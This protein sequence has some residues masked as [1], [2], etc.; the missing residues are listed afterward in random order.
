MPRYRVLA[1]S[2]INDRIVHPGDI[3]EYSGGE[4]SDNLELIDEPK[5]RR[6]KPAKVETPADVEDVDT[7]ETPADVE[8]VTSGEDLV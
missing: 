5:A 7:V 1:Q 8:D 6:G 2:F 4:V 3:V